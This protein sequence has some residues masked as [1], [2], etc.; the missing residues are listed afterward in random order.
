MVPPEVKEK[1][2]EDFVERLDGSGFYVDR[3]RPPESVAGV[4]ESGFPAP[5]TSASTTEHH[6]EG[7]P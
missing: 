1:I 7:R 4:I 6:P 3:P 2:A 5:D